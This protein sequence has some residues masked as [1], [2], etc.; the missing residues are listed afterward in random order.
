MRVQAVPGI[1]SFSQYENDIR[2]AHEA[3]QL[4]SDVVGLVRLD[5]SGHESHYPRCRREINQPDSGARIPDDNGAV[6]GLQAGQSYANCNTTFVRH[7][8]GS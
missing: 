4:L 1:H 5:S 8:L 6:K 7:R 3:M 2:D